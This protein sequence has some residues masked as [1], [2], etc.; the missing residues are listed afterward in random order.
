MKTSRKFLYILVAAMLLLSIAVSG[1]GRT[2]SHDAAHKPITPGRPSHAT[3]PTDTEPPVIATEPAPTK[4]PVVAT[5]P[6]PTEPPIV[7]AEPES[8]IPKEAEEFNGHYY[9]IYHVTQA[10]SWAEAKEYCESVGGYLATLTSREESDFVY[11]L[12]REKGRKAGS[13]GLS[14]VRDQDKWEW[15]TGEAFSFSNWAEGE[16]NNANGFQHYGAFNKE[17]A[18]DQWDD[19]ASHCDTFICEWGDFLTAEEQMEINKTPVPLS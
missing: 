14:N 12:L 9:C 13:F 18:G 16:P 11:S 19:A 6:A 10:L 3:Q 7:P 4:P 8:L 17:Y 15:V 2:I 5:E 1:C